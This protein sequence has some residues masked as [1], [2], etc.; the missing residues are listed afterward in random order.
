MD[1]VDERDGFQ[2]AIHVGNTAAGK[3]LWVFIPGDL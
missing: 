1:V 3:A 2:K